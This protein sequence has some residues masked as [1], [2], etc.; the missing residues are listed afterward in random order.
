MWHTRKNTYVNSCHH[1]AAQ[2]QTTGIF[3][4]GEERVI[5]MQVNA[6]A[7]NSRRL[8]IFIGYS[9]PL[10]HGIRKDVSSLIGTAGSAKTSLK[11]GFNR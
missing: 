11:R 7:T 3:R 6:R 1:E 9:Q 10:N 4:T 8:N 2:S 5:R